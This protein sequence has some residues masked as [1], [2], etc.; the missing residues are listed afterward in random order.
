MSLIS[1]REF[2]QVAA[3]TG[4]SPAVTIDPARGAIE[5]H[6]GLLTVPADGQRLYKLL[7]VENLLRSISGR[8]LYFNRVDSYRDFPDADPHDGELLPKDRNASAALRFQKAPDFSLADYYD[9]SRRRTYACCFSLKARS[10]RGK[11]GVVF[12]FAKLRATVNETMKAEN[13][14]KYNGIPCKQIFSVNYGVVQYV[15]RDQ[16]RQNLERMP[17]PIQYTYLKDDHFAEEL[18]MRI[19]LSALGI[20]RFVLDDG[21]EMEFPSGLQLG[22]DFG[23]AIGNGTITG[24]MPGPLP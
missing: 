1:A 15:P 18:E 2:P 20:G 6:A 13:G 10:A 22:F 11:V 21:Q 16:A 3:M 24:I 12:D 14:L 23:L 19:A 4:E 9:Q 17:N 8:Y 7:T 5:P